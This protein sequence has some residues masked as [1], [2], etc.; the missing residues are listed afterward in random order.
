MVSHVPRVGIVLPTYNRAK[1]LPEAFASIREQTFGDWE[2]IVVD[3]GSTDDTTA[4]LDRLAG[5]L[6]NPVVRI[7]R[8]NGG[9]AAAR[10]TGL[11]AVRSEYVAFLDSDDLWTPTHL[12][13]FVTILD[14]H[15]DVDL[16]FGPARKSKWRTSEVVE[17]NHFRPG[18]KP[19]PFLSLGTRSRGAAHLID[20]RRF[21]CTQIRDGLPCLL[22]ASVARRT[23]FDDLRFWPECRILEDVNLYTRA[24]AA[25]R[26]FAYVDDVHLE[27]RVHDDHA[28]FV[29]E[30]Q[31]ECAYDVEK[32]RTRLGQIVDVGE[33]LLARG[34]L[35]SNA[36]RELRRHLSDIE[37]WRLGYATLWM[38]GQRQHAL[39]HFCRAVKRWPWSARFWKTCVLSAARTVTST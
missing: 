30:S 9:P 10:N 4:V 21:L 12:A 24:I 35:P 13:E 27:Y 1:F 19:H 5:S 3:D 14:E 8:E 2:L 7:H 25:G 17:P 26:R 36:R 11:D 22:Q 6:P 23:F 28:S 31:G 33:S 15:A 18:G 39:S 20:D 34:D 32:S 29:G 16:V 37:F 38:H